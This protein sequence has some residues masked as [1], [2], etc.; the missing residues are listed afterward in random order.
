MLVSAFLHALWHAAARTRPNPGD[1]LI[2]VVIAAGIW[3]ILMLPVTGLPSLRSL[4]FNLLAALANV[5][6]FILLLKA[7][8]RTDFVIAYPAGRAA[9]APLVLI[10]AFF[11]FG[12]WPHPGA[13]AGIFVVGLAVGLLALVAARRSRVDV[14]GL[15]FALASACTTAAYAMIDA[16]VVRGPGDP[17]SY[18]ASATIANSLAFAIVFHIQGRQ[19]LAALRREACFSLIASIASTSSYMIYI[20]AMQVAPVAAVSAIRETSVFFGIVIAA[21]WLRER[22]RFEHWAAGAL[23]VVG[24]VLIRLA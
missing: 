1:A 20:F 22:V 23:A 12:E 11:A 5:L 21:I 8:A 24:I 14:A 13:I 4:G 18:A 3:G 16:T 2:A 17:W 15:M 10:F 9:V 19:P 7:Y 6:N